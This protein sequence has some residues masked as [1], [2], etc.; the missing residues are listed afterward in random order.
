VNSLYLPTFPEGTIIWTAPSGR[1]YPTHPGA[2]M[3]LPDWCISTEPL[4]PAGTGAPKTAHRSLRM[5]RRR[6]TRQADRAQ[7]IKN[8]R[9]QNDSS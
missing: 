8:R 1:A 4:P 7:R 9:A 6:R 2:R 3:Y 5:P